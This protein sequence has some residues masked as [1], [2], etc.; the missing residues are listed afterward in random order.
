M[1]HRMRRDW[2]V[3]ILDDIRAF[4]EE[5]QLPEMAAEIDQL[6]QKYGP[7]LMADAVPVE[8]PTAGQDAENLIRFPGHSKPI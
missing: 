8:D 4:L 3:P 1:P 7:I 2:V 5:S 6:M